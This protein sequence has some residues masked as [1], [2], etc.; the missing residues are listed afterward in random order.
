MYVTLEDYEILLSEM[1]EAIDVLK[2]TSEKMIYPI[3]NSEDE[4][5]CEINTYRANSILAKVKVL[6]IEFGKLQNDLNQYKENTS[7]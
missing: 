2:E 4:K 7:N 6:E 3:K 5:P 1:K